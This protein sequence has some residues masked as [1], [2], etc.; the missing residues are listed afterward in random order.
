MFVWLLCVGGGRLCLN[1]LEEDSSEDAC[2]NNV[3]VAC[4]NVGGSMS[5]ER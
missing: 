3:C 5:G 4:D 2:C 1:I